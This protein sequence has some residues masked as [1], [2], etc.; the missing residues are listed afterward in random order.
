MNARLSPEFVL[1][2]SKSLDRNVLKQ[3]V[4]AL[5]VSKQALLMFQDPILAVNA[6]GLVYFANR[7]AKKLLNQSS[8]PDRLPYLLEQLAAPVL[9]GGRDHIPTTFVDAISLRVDHREAF[10]LPFIL[11][12]RDEN[13]AGSPGVTIILHDLTRLS[14]HLPVA[15]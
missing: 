6:D 14:R 15:S 5:D 7:A 11:R 1:Q 12:I 2:P 9:E 3:L 10:Y 4:R 13:E 8:S